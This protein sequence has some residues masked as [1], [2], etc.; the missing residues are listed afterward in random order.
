MDQHFPASKHR[1]HFF[2]NAKR[3]PT[4][5]SFEI[6]F[7]DLDFRRFHSISFAVILRPLIFQ[8]GVAGAIFQRTIPTQALG[9][10]NG[11]YQADGKA[12]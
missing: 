12:D 2:D 6:R 10:R 1:F 5:A 9:K 8:H 3:R 11:E 7:P 4:T